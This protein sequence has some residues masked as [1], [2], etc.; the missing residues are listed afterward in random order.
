MKFKDV[1]DSPLRSIDIVQLR[2]VMKEEESQGARNRS[3]AIILLFQD[4]RSFE[5][6]ASFFNVHINT[7]HNWAGRWT[8]E[9][10]NGVYDLDG[11][12]VKP[13][14]SEG[15]EKIILECLEIDP[16]SLKKLDAI[17]MEKTGKTASLATYRRIIKKHGK[18][19]KRQRKT[20]KGSPTKDEY[21]RGV[22][23]IAELKDLAKDGEFNLIYFDASGFS[24]QPYIPYAWQDVGR[25]GTLRIAASHSMRIN[26]LAFFNPSAQE[27]VAYEPIGPMTS[28]VLIDIMDDFSSLLTEPVVV[29][30][31]NAPIHVSRAVMNRRE[32]W[33]KRGLTLY[34]L[35]PYSPELNLIE[36]LW[37]KMKYEWMPSL[38]YVSMTALSCAV[39]RIIESFG[40]EF[41]IEFAK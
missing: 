37:R 35:P 13:I 21:E 39:H 14:F 15:D 32:L 31:D 9:G 11:R 18:S 28:L 12:G 10:I 6:V 23:D 8:V 40:S 38:A 25:A 30:L 16:R 24:L 7:I 1:L 36:I 19:W 29:V 33:E 34:F 5:D 22:S 26:V 17:V 41:R 2:Q 27:L 20:P 3:H 4:H